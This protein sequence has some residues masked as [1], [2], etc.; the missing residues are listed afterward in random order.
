MQSYSLSNMLRFFWD[1]RYFLHPLIFFFT[2]P[3]LI[4]FSP[5]HYSPTLCLSI[6]Y[7]Y[8]L[9]FL[10]L[11]SHY[12]IFFLFSFR[13][14]PLPITIPDEGLCP[15]CRIF[16]FISIFPSFALGS[17]TFSDCY[18]YIYN[19]TEHL[20]VFLTGSYYHTTDLAK[21]L[22]MFIYRWL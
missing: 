3:F 22:L 14:S 20:N 8:Y 5:S 4:S 21:L 19:C 2:L 11:K 7:I 15:K 16:I 17:L 18:S 10:I 1:T 12:Y 6:I 13:S 9:P